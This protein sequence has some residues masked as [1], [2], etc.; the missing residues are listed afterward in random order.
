[1]KDSRLLIVGGGWSFLQ[2]MSSIDTRAIVVH[3]LT[4]WL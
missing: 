3:T 1:M 2:P 4:K